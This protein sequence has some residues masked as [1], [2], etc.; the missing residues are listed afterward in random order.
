M[1]DVT[2]Y[3]LHL[4]KDSFAFFLT[5][6]A[7]QNIMARIKNPNGKQIEYNENINFS[8]IE[9]LNYNGIQW[10]FHSRIYLVINK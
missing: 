1:F 9:V 2:C 3:K 4:A 6:K 7:L 8:E 5:A 10:N